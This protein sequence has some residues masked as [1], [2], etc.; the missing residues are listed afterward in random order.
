MIVWILELTVNVTFTGGIVTVG[1]LVIN[2]G[3][4]KFSNVTV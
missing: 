3:K 4:G 2:G 1:N